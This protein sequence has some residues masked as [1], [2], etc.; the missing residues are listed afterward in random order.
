MRRNKA[1]RERPVDKFLDRVMLER[2]PAI[3]NGHWEDQGCATRGFAAGSA[4]D[5]SYDRATAALRRWVDGMEAAL[6]KRGS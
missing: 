5:P 1:N 2:E 3:A 6:Q 4:F